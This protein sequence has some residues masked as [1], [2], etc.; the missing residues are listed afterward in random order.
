MVLM[1]LSGNN[2][3]AQVKV[4]GDVY[5]GGNLAP[6]GGSCTV[7]IDVTPPTDGNKNVAGDVYGGGALANTNTSEYIVKTGLTVGTSDVTGLYERTG[8]GTDA[9]PYEYTKITTA[10]TAAANKT[11][12]EKT[13]TSVTLTKGQVNGSVYGGG[14]GDASHAANV[15]GAVTVT[16]NGGTATNV[17]G[18]NNVNGAPQSTVEVNISGGEVTLDVYGGGNLASTTVSPVVN[19]TGGTVTRD[20]YGGGALA[21]TG[22]STV[23]VTSGTVT[24]DVY[25]GGLGDGDYAALENGTVTVNIGAMQPGANEGD[26][27]TYS[28]EATIGGSV[29]GCNNANGSPQGDVF[30]NIYQTKHIAA[31]TYPTDVDDLTKLATE[32]EDNEAA[33][34]SS[35]FAI[36]AVYG[37][38]NKAAYNPAVKSEGFYKTQVHVYQ[39]TSNTIQTV[40]G[41]GNAA[42]ATNVSV[43]IDGGFFD[44]IFGGGNGAGNHDDTSAADYNPGANITGSAI[45]QIHGGLYRQVFGGS[46]SKGDVASA[47]LTLDTESD[48]S[49][50]VLLVHESFGGANEADITGNI[51]TTLAC[52][53]NQI[54][55]FYGGSNLADIEGDVTLNV[56]GGTYTNVFGGSKGRAANTTVTPAITAKPANITGDVTLNLYGGT[57]DNAFGG[58]DVNGNIGGTITVNMLDR[59][60]CDLTVHNIYG[61]GRDAAYTPTLGEGETERISPVINLIHGTVSKKTVTSGTNTTYVRG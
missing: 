60:D 52:S 45:T 8:N 38:G 46:N 43:I 14:L 26:N 49:P 6:V 54:G 16:V 59:G 2:A 56:Y 36:S 41:G 53:S 18:C 37:G 40:Y 17:F 44:Q 55:S 61:G 9:S 58:S 12:C 13:T 7:V 51:S 30:V 39:C 42:N 47:S 48:C 33:T 4:N 20:V 11:Y 19:V 35:K 29:F 28:G 21:N 24:R 27:P 15:G 31:N 5:G 57:I 23:N 34:Y 32:V 22:G 10:T 3:L 50:S 1:S 25:G